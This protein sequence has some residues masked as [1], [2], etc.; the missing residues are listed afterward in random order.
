MVLQLVTQDAKEKNYTY[1]RMAAYVGFGEI[2]NDNGDI[3][4]EYPSL[5]DVEIDA[6]KSPMTIT[7]SV[8]DNDGYY[9]IGQILTYTLEQYVPYVEPGKQDYKF[10]VVDELF[11]AKYYLT[12]EKSVATIEME[13]EDGTSEL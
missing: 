11:N 8:D 2:K 1:N 6:K 10:E 9:A 7:K 13:K 12:G 4:N 5:L 3:I